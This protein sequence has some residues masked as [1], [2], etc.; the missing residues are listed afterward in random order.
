MII[1]LFFVLINGFDIS[2]HRCTKYPLADRDLL[3]GC[4]SQLIDTNHDNV[5]NSTEVN[6]FNNHCC[7][8]WNSNMMT[9][10][11]YFQ[12]ACDINKD[13]LLDLSDWNHRHACCRQEGCLTMLCA[14][15]Y[16]HGW[17]GPPTKK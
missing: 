7:S 11:D 10:N 3:L 5:L 6:A 2:D 12:M 16:E 13:N 1:L 15:C 9:P 14:F 8:T 17:T 4:F